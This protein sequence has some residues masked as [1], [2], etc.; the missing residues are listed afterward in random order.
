MP[1]N[2]WNQLGNDIK[3]IVQDAIETGDY[4]RL[5]RDLGGARWQPGRQLLC[6]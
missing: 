6:R 1:K 4:G 2:D 3:N 5:N